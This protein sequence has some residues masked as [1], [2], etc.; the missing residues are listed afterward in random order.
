MIVERG[1]PHTLRHSFATNLLDDGHD[2]RP[3]QGLLG[4]RD[5]STIMID[6]HVLNRS[7][8]GVRSPADRIFGV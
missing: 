8:A 2:V 4:H 3:G 5:V 7:P 1:S 6:T